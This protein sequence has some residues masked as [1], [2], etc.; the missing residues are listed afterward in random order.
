MSQIEALPSR[1]KA[2]GP[3][4]ELASPLRFLPETSTETKIVLTILMVLSIWGM[5]ILSIGVA[6]LVWPMK[7]IVPLMVLALVLITWSK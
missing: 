3:M 4:E 1:P 7:F 2:P 5:A 6:A